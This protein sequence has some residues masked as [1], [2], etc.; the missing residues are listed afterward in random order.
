MH[1]SEVYIAY[2]HL[3]SEKKII[4]RLPHLLKKRW[5]KIFPEGAFIEERKD[6]LCFNLFRIR[7]NVN[8]LARTDCSRRKK[9]SKIADLTL[10]K[11]STLAPVGEKN[12]KA[13]NSKLEQSIYRNN[14][15][16]TSFLQYE[17]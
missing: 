1:D 6:T 3:T 15:W 11:S 2:L 8:L 16:I 10:I 5:A 14:K 17:W 4:T 13:T 7:C 9:N 12:W